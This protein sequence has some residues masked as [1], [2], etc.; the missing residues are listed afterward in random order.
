VERALDHAVFGFDRRGHLADGDA[1]FVIEAARERDLADVAFLDPV[2]GLL[3]AGAGT[4]LHAV[5]NDEPFLRDLLG[6][7]QELAA[8][9]DVVADGL[10]HI[11]VLACGHGG[12]GDERVRVVRRGDG[13]GV[14]LGVEHELPVIG[15]SGDGVVFLRLIRDFFLKHVAVHITQ[16][17]DAHAGDFLEALDVALAARVEADDRDTNVTIGTQRCR[18]GAG[19]DEPGSAG[20]GAANERA[21]GGWGVVF[22]HGMEMVE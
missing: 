17:H 19:R 6:S 11:D 12:H 14:H 18:E 7:V 5:L 10:F 4:A 3:P 13:D 8:F 1:G 16:G 15:V 2:H 20:D 9:P 22:L 21:A